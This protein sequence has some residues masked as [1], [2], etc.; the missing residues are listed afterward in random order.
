[1]SVLDGGV[2]TASAMVRRRALSLLGSATCSVPAFVRTELRT[3]RLAIAKGDRSGT[4]LH[5]RKAQAV[6]P[7]TQ[8]ER[9][10][11]RAW[12]EHW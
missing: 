4:A 8:W 9:E 11:E 5:P 1:M 6:T 2:T 10:D 3:V 12:K 7:T